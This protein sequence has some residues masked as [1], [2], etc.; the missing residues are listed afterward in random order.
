MA[1]FSVGKL[2]LIGFYLYYFIHS[3]IC[4]CEDDHFECNNGAC[5]HVEHVCNYEDNCGDGS[6]EIESFCVDWICHS[7]THWK[8]DDGYCIWLDKVC[9]GVEFCADGSDETDT[10]CNDWICPW[11]IYGWQFQCDNNRCI[12]NIL[13]CNGVDDCGDYS[14]EMQFLCSN[15][16]CP[17]DYDEGYQC[18]NGYCIDHQRVCN[19]IDDCGDYS[20]ESNHVCD[21]WICPDTNNQ[22]QCN[23]SRCI[24]VNT[25]CNGDDDCGDL[26]DETSDLCSGNVCHDPENT[27]RC[28]YGGCIG[29][30]D[31]YIVCDGYANCLDGSDEIGCEL[32]KCEYNSGR[33]NFSVSDRKK[34]NISEEQAQQIINSAENIENNF[35]INIQDNVI[36]ISLL[37]INVATALF[38][39]TGL[40][41]YE[42]K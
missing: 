17:E 36:L 19:G 16:T 7:D 33:V 23:K 24:Y 22:S 42:K 5:I 27:F 20:D 11:E 29:N 32:Y 21:D 34:Y 30:V 38:I 39:I 37:F 1:T 41:L 28:N 10:L 12:D 40:Y 3:V 9:N 15:Y 8:C 26:S 14:D 2:C 35:G 13:F 31:D 6:D 4:N 25:I 18:D